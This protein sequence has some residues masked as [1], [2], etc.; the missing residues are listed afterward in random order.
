VKGILLAAE[1]NFIL[2][3][4]E[5]DLFSA[6]ILDLVVTRLFLLASAP[7]FNARRCLS[8]A[9]THINFQ[10][11]FG[12]FCG[13]HDPIFHFL[14]HKFFEFIYLAPIVIRSYTY[15]YDLRALILYAFFLF[16]YLL[17]LEGALRARPSLTIWLW[18]TR[19]GCLF[20]NP[21]KCV[22]SFHSSRKSA[23]VS[24]LRRTLGD[25]KVLSITAPLFLQ[26]GQLNSDVLHI[27][28]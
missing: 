16:L 20:M 2:N 13:S 14:F 27:F 11:I 23:M 28:S 1:I 15:M 10:D 21:N 8:N 25:P 7:S 17:P 18:S 22:R 6:A 5:K 19:K 4:Y 24:T 9:F 26:K 3:K 12:L